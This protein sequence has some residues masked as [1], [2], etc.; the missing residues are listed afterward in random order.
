[1]SPTSANHASQALPPDTEPAA[2]THTSTTAPLTAG[3]GEARN[4]SVPDTSGLSPREIR[5]IQRIKVGREQILDAAE[6]L[7]GRSGYR[8][9]S[10]QQVAKRCEFSIGALYLFIDSKEELLR[11]V[12]ERRFVALMSEM[13]QCVASEGPAHE[14]LVQLALTLVAFH[15]RY[16]DFARL[17]IMIMSAGAET[18]PGFDEE[19]AKD[20]QHTIDIEAELFAR[21]QADGTIRAGDPRSL[22]R[23]F[24]TMVAAYHSLDPV[25]SPGGT[26]HLADEDFLDCVSRA[27]AA[28]SQAVIK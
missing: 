11:G 25:V 26:D 1:M 17:S 28:S 16:P 6:E 19:V 27:F 2:H 3:E 20:Y 23:L 5:R 12:L 10:L 7:F 4:T 8:G 15:R 18:A 13:R 24:S 9:T 21:G 14:V 22:A